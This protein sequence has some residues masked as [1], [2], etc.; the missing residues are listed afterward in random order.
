MVNDDGCGW[1][2]VKD[3]TIHTPTSRRPPLSLGIDVR[4]L[5][6]ISIRFTRA[7]LTACSI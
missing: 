3:G 5:L 1:A 7:R 2:G 4:C 6:P